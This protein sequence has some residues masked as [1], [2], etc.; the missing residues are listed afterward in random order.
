MSIQRIKDALVDLAR[1]AAED[2]HQ[3]KHFP[4]DPE[5]L[6]AVLA[7]A[8]ERSLAYSNLAAYMTILEGQQNKE[9]ANHLIKESA[10]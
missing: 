10:R 2:A 8:E 6:K 3:L 4:E 5:T 7:R 1:Q 9:I